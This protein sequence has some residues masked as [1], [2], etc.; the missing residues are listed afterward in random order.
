MH[1]EMNATKGGNT[2]MQGYW[3]I[4][5]AEQSKLLRNRDNAVVRG[6]G[7]NVM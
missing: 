2:E 3:N 7:D 6:R 4:A 1:K 5:E